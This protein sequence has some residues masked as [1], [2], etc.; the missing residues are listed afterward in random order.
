MQ[1]HVDKQSEGGSSH[2][3]TSPSNHDQN[4]GLFELNFFF[5]KVYFLFLGLHIVKRQETSLHKCLN[6]ETSW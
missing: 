2:Q 4:E 5:K 6:N 1:L 3:K